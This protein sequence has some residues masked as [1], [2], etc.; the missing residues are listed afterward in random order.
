MGTAVA[1]KP[2]ET[3]QNFIATNRSRIEDAMPA[4]VRAELIT[5]SLM[6]AMRA[7]PKLASCTPKSLKYCLE[8]MTLTGLDVGQQLNAKAYLVPRRV[9]VS[10][11]GEPERHEM[12]A[13]FQIGYKGVKELVRRSGQGTLIMQ[14]VRDGDLFEDN[15]RD[16]MPTFKAA[17]D[18]L[19]HR[20]R[21]EWVYAAFVPRDNSTPIVS[22]WSRERC[23]DHRDNYSQGYYGNK[24]D[25][26]HE[27]NPSF[28][29]MCQ[30]CPVMELA[31]RGDLPLSSDVAQLA[32]S[33]DVMREIQ[34]V[35]VAALPAAE[36]SVIT[37][38]TPMED[39]ADEPI[40]IDPAWM[41]EELNK[42]TTER[43]LDIWQKK[44]CDTFGHQR[45]EIYDR[46]EE[47][48]DLIRE[49]SK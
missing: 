13:C 30:K 19:R 9:K 17:K 33:A 37:N 22:V 25:A 7:D 1:A 28:P 2:I 46:C 15:G 35:A 14:D 38:Q 29:V 39:P 10:K 4:G 12:Q 47:H 24:S 16:Q 41:E 32:E 27:D 6:A 48:R 18:P 31:G 45:Q 3:L 26:W 5:R 40:D 49:T 21:L 34:P 20:K 23:I 43:A 11:K 42:I 8:C 36:T 44:Q